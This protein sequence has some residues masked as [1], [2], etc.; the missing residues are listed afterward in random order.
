L[1]EL[2]ENAGSDGFKR[3]D[4]YEAVSNVLPSD[5]SVEQKLRIVGQL[6]KSMET[7]NEIHQEGRKWV[8]S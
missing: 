8:I 2:A 1:I 6:L 3:L 7:N 4:A 5:K